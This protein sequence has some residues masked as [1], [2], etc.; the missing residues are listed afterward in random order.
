MEITPT[1]PNFLKKKQITLL[2]NIDEKKN[3]P[4]YKQS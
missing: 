1:L 4:L 3:P 2:L